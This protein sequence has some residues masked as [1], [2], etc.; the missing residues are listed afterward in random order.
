[1]ELSQMLPALS[2]KERK[3]LTLRILGIVL[4]HTFVT[5]LQR[6]RPQA[7][8]QDKTVIL[9]PTQQLRLRSIAPNMV[10]VVQKCLLSGVTMLLQRI[11]PYAGMDI[12]EKKRLLQ[13]LSLRQSGK[14]NN[15]SEMRL[16]LLRRPRK[17]RGLMR[18]KRR[19]KK[20]KRSQTQSRQPIQP[21]QKM[22]LKKNV[23]QHI[24]FQSVRLGQKRIQV[25]QKSRRL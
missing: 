24:L 3:I 16:S 6:R 15:S 21:R 19:R 10:Q 18:R 4:I 2:L 20:K 25:I 22:E 7:V 14:K 17:L 5:Q 1:M 8:L 23:L 9:M 11:P 13:T 12:A